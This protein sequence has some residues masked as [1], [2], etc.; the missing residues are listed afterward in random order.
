M[1]EEEALFSFYLS[2]QYNKVED[3]TNLLENLKRERML[4]GYLATHPKALMECS[5]SSDFSIF[6]PS[7][8]KMLCVDRIEIHA[9]RELI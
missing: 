5:S 8:D 3:A 1:N 6:V 9:P 4:D 7:F 2:V